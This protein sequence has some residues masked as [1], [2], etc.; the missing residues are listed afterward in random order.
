MTDH[1]EEV[2]SNT[3]LLVIICI[4]IAALLFQRPES[5]LPVLDIDVVLLK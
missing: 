2:G 5:L 3:V 1:P 4:T